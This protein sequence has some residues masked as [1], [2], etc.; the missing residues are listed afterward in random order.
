MEHQ[1][2]GAPAPERHEIQE[3]AHLLARRAVVVDHAVGAREARDAR[4]REPRER[5][6]RELARA[7][8]LDHPVAEA[9]GHARIQ[10][11]PPPI[12]LHHLAGREHERDGVEGDAGGV[13]VRGLGDAV[14]HQ[15]G[16]LRAEARAVRERRHRGLDRAARPPAPARAGRPC[17]TTAARAAAWPLLVRCTFGR[18]PAAPAGIA[19][20]TA[21]SRPAASARAVRRVLGLFQFT[22]IRIGSAALSLDASRQGRPSC[23]R[24]E[25]WR[26]LA[27]PRW[28]ARPPPPPARHRGAG[29]AGRSPARRARRAR[30]GAR[31]TRR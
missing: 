3:D 22:L 30:A 6:E 14:D 12:H 7:R 8:V 20:T 31:S 11:G 19:A 4:E 23:V 25:L 24:S 27:P 5:D 26:Q 29:R 15:V 28:P 1:D 21:R 18:S 16:L 13:A 10:H 2:L 17:V 9:G